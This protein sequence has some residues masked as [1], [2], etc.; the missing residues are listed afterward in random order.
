MAGLI[1]GTAG[2]LDLGGQSDSVSDEPFSSYTCPPEGIDAEGRELWCSHTAD[3]DDRE[4]VLEPSVEQ[5]PNPSEVR[6]HLTNESETSMRFNP[7][8]W[9]IWLEQSGEWRA[10]EQ[11]WVGDGFADLGPGQTHEW[12]FEEV[13]ELINDRFDPEPATYLAAI[14]TPR[15]SPA[16]LLRITD[17]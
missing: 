15:G 3:A 17:D 13:I 16:A 5:S 10:L 9:S 12:G 7:A 8:S 11:T 2:C 6:L 4:L 14:A 1:A